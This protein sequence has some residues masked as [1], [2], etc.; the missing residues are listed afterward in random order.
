MHLSISE[1]VSYREA[2]E[3]VEAALEALTRKWPLTRILHPPLTHFQE[4]GQFIL[5]LNVSC[6]EISVD[7]TSANT[8]EQISSKVKPR[9][10][11]SRSKRNLHLSHNY[12]CSSRASTSWISRRNMVEH[13]AKFHMLQN[14]QELSVQE[15]MRPNLSSSADL[16]M[17]DTCCLLACLLVQ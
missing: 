16:E 17:K 9:G 15:S 11:A 13:F 12:C 8:H 5:L 6:E 1:G 7:T 14:Q 3:P 4:S 10:Q 2:T